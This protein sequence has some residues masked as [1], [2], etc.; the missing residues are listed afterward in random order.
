[1]ASFVTLKVT[2]IIP[3][4]QPLHEVDSEEKE[5]LKRS[6]EEIGLVYPLVVTKAGDKY[7]ILDG[8]TRFQVIQQLKW[9][10]VP[11]LIVEEADWI[12]KVTRIPYEMELFRRHLNLAERRK[13]KKQLDEI[14]NKPENV[15]EVLK[16]FL[17]PKV[18]EKIKETVLDKFE[19]EVITGIVLAI[20]NL[21]EEKQLQ[22]ID[23]FVAGSSDA[24]AEALRTELEEKTSEIK[25]LEEE[26]EKIQKEMEKQEEYFVS[27]FKEKVE[28]ELEK[29]K[30]ELE[31]LYKGE[32]D[33][34]DMKRLMEEERE[35]IYREYKEEIDEHQKTIER[36]TKN[37]K[38]KAE[39]I[40]D[41]EEQKKSFEEQYKCASEEA[42]RYREDREYFAKILE[43][44]T[45]VDKLKKELSGILEELQSIKKLLIDLGEDYTM[46]I[47][48]EGINEV[49][50]MLK[51]ISKTA[52]EVEGL[53]REYS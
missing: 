4:K 11:C 21:P 46:E 33:E 32:L 42:E 53:F 9:N 15:I 28:K 36:L 50:S 44:I 29:K 49:M 48:K 13:Y 6:I 26:K 7:R 5:K 24:I 25:R 8:R 18:V 43:S 14:L 2:E 45:G 23:K 31:K 47:P 10:F 35:K 1:M 12:T 34:A 51:D 39:K 20:K 17:N 3:T 37:I 19:P 16:E 30:K 52:K 22:V 40:K 27:T 38:D 41:L